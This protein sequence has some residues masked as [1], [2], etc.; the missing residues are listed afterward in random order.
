MLKQ[1]DI[2][3]EFQPIIDGPPQAPKNLFRQAASNDEVTIESW[4]DTWIENV[5]KNHAVKGPFAG[6]SIGELFGKYQGR[7]C[8]VVG[9]GP[10]LKGNISD[11]AEASLHLPVVSCLHNFHFLEDNGVQVD[12]YVT[13]DAGPVTVEEV[14]EGGTR[15]P[16]EYWALTKGKKLLAFIGSHPELIS[17]WQ[18][19]IYWFHCPIPDQGI[20]KAIEEVEPFGVFISNGGTVLGACFYAAKAIMAANPIIFAGADFSFSYDKKFHGWDSKYDQKLGQAFKVTDIFGNRRYTWQ[21]YYNFKCWFDYVFC[22][23]PGIY[24]NA[25]EGG[26]MGAYP[27]G[28]IRQV[29]QISMTEVVTMYSHHEHLREQC[30]EPAGEVS[31][32]RPVKL[33]F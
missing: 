29:Q 10:S 16:E 20:M 1:I 6:S 33:L 19:E 32:D 3:L 28:N 25:T 11:L 31:T 26:C 5:Q 24:L 30:E 21:S 8:I 13:L 2:E 22:T 9:S 12:Y 18:G 14:Y 7:G 17:R 4:R 27:E 15:K 23:V